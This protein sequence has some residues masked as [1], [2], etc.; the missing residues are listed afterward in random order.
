M[1]LAGNLCRSVSS[2]TENYFL[3]ITKKRKGDFVTQHI[4][5]NN[6]LKNYIYIIQNYISIIQKMQN[7]QKFQSWTEEHKA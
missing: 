3:P 4:F 7:K 2:T 1:F 5:L 6:T